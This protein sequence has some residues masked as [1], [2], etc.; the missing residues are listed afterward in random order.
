M[1]HNC[2]AFIG[3]HKRHQD[4]P[5]PEGP[6]MLSGPSRCDIWTRYAKFLKTLRDKEVAFMARLDYDYDK[7]QGV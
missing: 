5:N 1:G 7:H 2:R 3:L 4:I 6:L